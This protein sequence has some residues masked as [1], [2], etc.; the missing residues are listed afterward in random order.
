LHGGPVGAFRC[1]ARELEL[2]QTPSWEAWNAFLSRHI[3]GDPRSKMIGKLFAGVPRDHALEIG[4]KIPLCWVVE[5]LR[6]EMFSRR[7]CA[8]MTEAFALSEWRGQIDD[9][10]GKALARA[11]LAG[12]EEL[13]RWLADHC[14]ENGGALRKCLGELPSL[15]AKAGRFADA[16]GAKAAVPESL[17]VHFPY[18]SEPSGWAD[19]TPGAE[20][21]RLVEVALSVFGPA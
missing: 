13:P 3:R 21:A 8:G 19:L 12:D 14:G 1:L 5:K 10:L 15:L 4:R 6:S 16:K 18:F 7:D 17:D 2:G 9:Q 11:L 20:G